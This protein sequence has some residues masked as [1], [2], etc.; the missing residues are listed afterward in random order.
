MS[1]NGAP[2]WE[3]ALPYLKPAESEDGTPSALISDD[4]AP[5]LLDLGNGLLVSFLMDAGDHFVYLQGEDLAATGVEPP[6]L[7][8]RA[9]DNLTRRVQ[10]EGL[11]VFESGP[12]FALRLDGQ[13]EASLLLLDWLWEQELASRI[14]R[15]YLACVPARDILAFCDLGSSDGAAELQALAAN[16]DGFDHPISGSLFVRQSG[17]WIPWSGGSIQ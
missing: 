9:L 6:E 5:I 13:F 1:A 8:H 4:N 14:E 12:V 10:E 16:L 11:Q 7:Y 3:S 15:G 2:I 17:M